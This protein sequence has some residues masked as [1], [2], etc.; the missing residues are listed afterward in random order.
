[1]NGCGPYSTSPLGLIPAQSVVLEIVVST[2]F[3]RSFQAEGSVDLEHRLFIGISDLNYPELHSAYP[4]F[5]FIVMQL[6]VFLFLQIVP[7]RCR[8][9]DTPCLSCYCSQQEGERGEIMPRAG[10]PVF[11]NTG[12]HSVRTTHL[13]GLAHFVK[14]VGLSF[15]DCGEVISVISDE[16]I[17]LFKFAEPGW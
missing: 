5:S 10:M 4:S 17:T 16:G 7:G 1:M 8:A 11:Q 14:C 9:V 15:E 12:T 13:Y 3:Q 6:E 2:V